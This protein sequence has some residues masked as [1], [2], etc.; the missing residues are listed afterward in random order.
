M[1]DIDKE[2]KDAQPY[3]LMTGYLASENWII[4]EKID[5]HFG[6]HE[7]P[8]PSAWPRP[9]YDRGTHYHS[10]HEA[11]KIE[12]SEVNKV[13]RESVLL[14]FDVCYIVLSERMH[15]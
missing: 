13:G 2:Q 9:V 4:R 14:P 1:V 3:H 11:A 12:P 8:L 10:N 15:G 5:A 6:T 7:R